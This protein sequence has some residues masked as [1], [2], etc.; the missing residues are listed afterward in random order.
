MGYSIATK[1]KSEDLKLRFLGFMKTHS[2]RWSLVCGKEQSEWYGSASDP[3]DDLSYEHSQ[4][5]IG[6]DYQSGMFDFERDYIYSVL[7]WMAIKV[8]ERK[9]RMLVDEDEEGVVMHEFPEPIPYYIYDGGSILTP[10]LVVTEEQA[11]TLPKDQQQWA[12]D[13]LGVRIGP[14]VVDQQIG[15]CSGMLGELGITLM[16]ETRVLGSPPPEGD[17]DEEAWWSKRRA[18]YLKYLKPEIDKSIALIRQEIQRLDKLWVG[19]F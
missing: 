3:T 8:G 14:T 2:R 4:D 1:V 9:D 18:I 12:V 11:A 6:F 10:I 15:S 16:E 13:E 19:E 17:P 5:M 7:R